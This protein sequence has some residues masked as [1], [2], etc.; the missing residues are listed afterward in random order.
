[1]KTH[2]FLL[3]GAALATLAACSPRQKPDPK[4]DAP[5]QAA[6]AAASEGTAAA[7]P[8]AAFTPGSVTPA[9]PGKAAA[10]AALPV[11]GPAPAWELKDLNGATVRSADF[12]GKVVVVDFWATWCPPCRAEIPGYVELYKKYGKDRLAIVGVS[13]DQGGADQVKRFVERFGITYPIVMGDEAV[14]SAFGGMEAIP[15]TFLIDQ[16]GRIRDK[17]VG[18]EPTEEYEKKIAALL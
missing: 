2:P 7:A 6:V 12:K 15:T 5:S 4:V 18:A 9:A 16:Q 13:L 17:K 11:I 14:Q 10:E 1:M 3:A 8:T